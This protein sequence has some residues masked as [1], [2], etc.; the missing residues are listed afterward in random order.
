MVRRMLDRVGGRCLGGRVKARDRVHLNESLESTR[1]LS[2]RE[3]I[4]LV[5]STI[6]L[7]G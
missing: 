5:I 7:V 2:V 3:A 6:L 1:R 4:G